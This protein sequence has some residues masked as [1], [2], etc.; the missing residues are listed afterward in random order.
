M[1]RVVTLTVTVAAS[2]EFGTTSV[3]EGLP[4]DPRHKLGTIPDS[5]F[6]NRIR[7]SRP[8]A[9]LIPGPDT[10]NRYYLRRQSQYGICTY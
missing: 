6:D 1:V 8:R 5:I 3:W 7:C 10:A 4:L 2:D 9:N